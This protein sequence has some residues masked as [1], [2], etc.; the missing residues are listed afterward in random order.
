MICR[1]CGND[2]PA[3]NRFCQS[4]GS[5][6]YG[7][8]SPSR[9][10]PADSPSRLGLGQQEVRGGIRGR[11]VL[12]RPDGSDGG[13]HPLFDGVNLLGRGSGPLFDAD[14]Y[15]SPVHVRI[16]VGGRDGLF[17]VRDAGSLNGVFLKLSEEEALTE[18]G[19]FRCGQQ[20]LR[21]DSIR[22]PRPMP[23]G[24]EVMGSPNPGYWG[25]LTLLIGRA[26]DGR[27][28]EGSSFPLSGDTLVLGRERGDI[29]FSEDGYCSGTHARLTYRGGRAFLQDLASS[30]GTYL[31]LPGERLVAA[32]TYLLLGQQ[33]FRIQA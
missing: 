26:S 17:V 15:L 10:G 31:R 20:L 19:V 4:C 13:A 8:D 21:L 33:L 22:P 7:G 12:V 2:N 30:N 14:S 5:A 28:I 1:V 9:L 23:D 16:E 27:V 29:V 11:L 3:A 18:G 24:T 25:R 32:G 6:L